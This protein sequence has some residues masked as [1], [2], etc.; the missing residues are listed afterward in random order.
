[1]LFLLLLAVIVVVGLLMKYTMLGRGIYAFGGDPVSAKRAG[2]NIV[3]TQIFVF[4]FMGC[5]AG[6]GGLTRTVLTGSCQP[7]TLEGYEMTCIAAAVLG[8]TRLSGG[9]GTVKGALLGV[10]L[11]M[12]VNNNLILLGIP[13][14]WSKFVTGIFIILGIGISTYQTLRA[15]RV[16]SASIL[17]EETPAGEAKKE[18]VH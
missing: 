13:T 5:L 10:L 2:F 18:A 8:G 6:L 17:E 9:V 3:F 16:I 11:M 15:Q 7:T 4:A 12:I 14:Y 1:M